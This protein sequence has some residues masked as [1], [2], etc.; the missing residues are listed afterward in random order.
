MK[1]VV[2]TYMR[3]GSTWVCEALNGLLQ[4]KERY[5]VV[6]SRTLEAGM[7]AT[8]E[9]LNDLC[10]IKSPVVKTHIYTPSDLLKLDERFIKPEDKPYV[11]S[12]HRDFLDAL[13]SRVLYERHVR[14]AQKLPSDPIIQSLLDRYPTITD[15]GLISLLVETQS[16]F[17]LKQIRLWRLFDQT[18][19]NPYVIAVPY[20]QI[21]ESPDTLLRRFN[22]I[23]CA[24]SDVVESTTKSLSLSNMKKKHTEGFVRRGAIGDHKLYLDDDSRNWIRQ[25]IRKLNQKRFTEV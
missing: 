10:S 4:Q 14:P 3:V 5:A 16:I 13:V 12:V 17:L 19:A 25:E 8:K 18:I 24:T 11:I 2:A 22:Q 15:A 1:F 9:E 7:S 23:I 6:T 21:V 20:K